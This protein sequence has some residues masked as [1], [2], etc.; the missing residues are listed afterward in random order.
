MKPHRNRPYPAAAPVAVGVLGAVVAE[1]PA[2][3]RRVGAGIEFGVRNRNADPFRGITPAAPVAIEI[4]FAGH[5]GRSRGRSCTP[6]QQKCQERGGPP[7]ASQPACGQEGNPHTE[8]IGQFSAGFEFGAERGD[9][10]S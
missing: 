9:S 8:G 6:A 3:R 2:F 4:V 1:P 10:R 5:L 7:E